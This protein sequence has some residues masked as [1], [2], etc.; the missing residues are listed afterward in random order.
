EGLHDGFL[1]MPFLQGRR[2]GR[3]D[4]EA[5]PRAAAYIGWLG[6]QARTGEAIEGDELFAMIERNVDLALGADARP[7]LDRWRRRLAGAPKV[8]IDGR[9]SPYEWLRAGETVFKT[10]GVDHGDDHFLPGSTDIG[11]DVAGFATE[12]GLGEEACADFAAEAARQAGDPHL[13]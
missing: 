11:W 7:R 12:W 13:P 5:L 1:T 2:L 9:M 3:R 10:D 4:P 8:E 6:R